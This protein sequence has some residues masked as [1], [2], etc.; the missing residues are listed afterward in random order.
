VTRSLSV[1]ALL[2]LLVLTSACTTR[3]T[4]VTVDD[5]SVHAETRSQ[6]GDQSPAPLDGSIIIRNA[7]STSQTL[8]IVELTDH[9]SAGGA[10]VPFEPRNLPVLDGRVRH[11]TYFPDEPMLTFWTVTATGASVPWS[12]TIG[13]GEDP[14][15][16]PVFLGLTLAPGQ[17]IT[18]AGPSTP[19]ATIAFINDRIGA[20]EAGAFA[21]VRLP[22]LSTPVPTSSSTPT[23]IPADDPPD[24]RSNT[25]RLITGLVVA[26]ALVVVLGGVVAAL[27]LRYARK[28]E[29]Q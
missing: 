23:P 28:W 6:E 9:N 16:R 7:A 24:G 26:I 19:G 25:T 1:L 10:A 14:P 27:V 18:I 22:E 2:P 21:S 15:E 5:E 4:E 29:R 17:T 20:Y 12:R 3:W 13:R 8:L 11:F